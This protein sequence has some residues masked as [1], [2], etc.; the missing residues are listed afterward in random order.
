MIT[1][2]FLDQEKR[3]I[4]ALLEDSKKQLD[5]FNQEVQN[6]TRLLYHL[7]GQL[8]QID[9]LLVFCESDKK[10]NGKKTGKNKTDKAK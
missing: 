5:Y 8:S 3:K 6:K 10:E 4:V 1:K 2:N 9:S 7:S